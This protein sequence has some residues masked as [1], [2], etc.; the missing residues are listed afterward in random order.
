M[1]PRVATFLLLM[2]PALAASAAQR[3]QDRA[4]RADSSSSRARLDA[5]RGQE[6]REDAEVRQLKTRVDTLESH[7]KEAGQALE[8]RDRR[9]A[10]LQRQLEA[11]QGH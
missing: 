6:K 7:S 3:P 8:E 4:T 10:E 2:L 1:N 11:A 9:I 5:L